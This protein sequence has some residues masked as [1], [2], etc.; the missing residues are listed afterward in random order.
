M[1]KLLLA[2]ALS[3]LIT[4]AFAKQID[5]ENVMVISLPGGDATVEL[6]PDKAPQTVAQIKTLVRQ[7]FYNNLEWFRVIDGFMAQTGYPK[8]SKGKSKLPDLPAEFTT[9]KFRRGT[10]GMGHGADINSANSQFF[11]CTSDAACK[12][13]TGK[14]TAFGQVTSGMELVDALAKGEPPAKPDKTLRARIAGDKNAP[15]QTQNRAKSG[16]NE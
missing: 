16:G 10:L 4:P 7:G 12:D 1:K 5:P 8:G 3:L 2:F 9:Y 14:Y 15:E 6:M 11:I 13:L